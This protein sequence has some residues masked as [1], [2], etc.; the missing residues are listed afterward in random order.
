MTEVYATILIESLTFIKLNV[1][2]YQRKVG[3]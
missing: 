3:S 2:S 1:L